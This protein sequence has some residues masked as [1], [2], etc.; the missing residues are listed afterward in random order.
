MCLLWKFST[1]L[2]SILKILEI[3]PDNGLVLQILDA[4]MSLAQIWVLGS[5]GSQ[6]IIG[7]KYR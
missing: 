3:T 2:K 1:C 6:H 7:K 5:L 4:I